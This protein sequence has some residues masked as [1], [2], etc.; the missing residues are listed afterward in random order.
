MS[1][2]KEKRTFGEDFA[3]FRRAL[4]I[5][6]KICPQ[7]I[8]WQIIN[9]IVTAVTPYFGIYMSAAFV[10]ELA[11]ACD[12]DRLIMLAVIT[13]AGGFAINIISRVVRG[14]LGVWANN[15][16]LRD[17]LFFLDTQ[18]RMQY[19]HLENPDVVLLRERIFA[20]KNANGGGLLQVQ[21]AI[22]N[23][24][25]S[26]AC[27]IASLALSVTVFTALPKEPQTGFLAFANSPWAVV[28]L[29]V[30]VAA[31]SI[32]LTKITNSASE[33]SA[34][35]WENLSG[36]NTR[37]GVYFNLW[38][39]DTLI[40]GMKRII[41]P[42]FAKL[43]I[44]PRFVANS[45]KIVVKSSILKGVISALAELW[46][47]I[48]VAA[49]AFAGAFGIGN[50]ILYR[51]TIGRLTGAVCDIGAQIGALRYNSR[52]LIDL[53]KYLDLP[54]DMYHGTLAVEKRDDIDYEIEFR[55]VSFRY[56]KTEIFALKNVN[57]KFRI[58]DKLAI[59][60][61]NG[62]GKTTFIKLLCR[63]YDPTE[64]TI[65]LNGIDI[66]RYRY[67]EYLALF[68][69]VFQDYKL[70]SFTIAENVACTHGYDAEKV[71]D[72][73]IRA[74]LEEKLKSL[75]K[76]IETALYRD[77]E[78]DGINLSGGEMQRMALARALYKDAPFAVLD[79]PTAAL[80]PIGEA[81]VYENFN[82]LVKNK[83]SVFISHRLSSCRFCDDIMVFDHGEIIQRGSH[84]ALI[85][86]E[87]GKYFAL[88][89]AQAQYYT[90]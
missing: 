34:K 86:D 62:S 78:N 4:K 42:E 41:L 14:R 9:S 88:W 23:L 67:D 17:E 74:G 37:V 84:D 60:G 1:K 26:I 59:V 21:W 51:A 39:S 53:Y 77:Y 72:C 58:G 27:I 50:Y 65:L 49:K 89:N 46:L 33:K 71:R 8:L 30:M 43:T 52:Y 13:V 6:L 73:L 19:N 44:R 45:N 48:I 56:P 22:P 90:K 80:D 10:N 18:N 83:T 47:F 63:L 57:M 68:S 16:W 54:D 5:L 76:G 82:S 69:V 15:S 31:E 7:Y 32:I 66:S 25:S 20:H 87:G 85:S 40:F 61:E 29:V 2:S 75:D 36:N 12:K 3:L 79:E 70:F 55:N 81:E 24:F 35:E 64:G 38:S 11:G 28:S